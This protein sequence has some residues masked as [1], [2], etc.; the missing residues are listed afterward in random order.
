M[1]KIHLIIT[2]LFIPVLM[3]FNGCSPSSGSSPASSYFMKATIGGTTMNGTVCIAGQVGTIMGITGSTV[4]SGVGGPPQ[5]NISIGN[6][7][8]APGSYT[9]AAISSPTN[10][11]GQY[12]SATGAI[13]KIS[14]SG[15]VT[16]SSIS[17]SEIKGSFN[18]TCTD[19][20]VVSA[21]SFTAK[22]Q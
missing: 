14:T 11:F 17:A 21:G 15:T 12:I 22:P 19:G 3:V 10:T 20:T 2:C 16:I 6:W 13:A 4:A 8:G 18:F 7:S 9:I 5:I 1:R